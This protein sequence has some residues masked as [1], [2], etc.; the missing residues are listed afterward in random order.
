[1]GVGDKTASEE[2][3]SYLMKSINE[4]ATLC[5]TISV[6]DAYVKKNVQSFV[7]A[8]QL[9]K[10]FRTGTLSREIIAD[11]IFCIVPLTSSAS[12]HLCP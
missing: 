5:Y 10:F 6:Q 9:N 2:N 11:G 8:H 1:M 3:L 7:N 12:S 4:P